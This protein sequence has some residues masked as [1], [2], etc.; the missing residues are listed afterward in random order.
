MRRT[1]QGFYGTLPLEFGGYGGYNWGMTQGY[2]Y[3]NYGAMN[4]YQAVP[5]LY[6]RNYFAGGP[7]YTYYTY[8]MYQPTVSVAEPQ[9]I[10]VKTARK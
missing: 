1:A 6:N 3:G 2:S 4:P 8:P 7:M 9:V 5:G 10:D